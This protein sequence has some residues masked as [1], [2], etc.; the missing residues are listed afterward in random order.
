VCGANKWMQTYHDRMPVIL[1]EKDFDG[2][3]D[4]SLGAGA[5]KCAS[6][7]VLREWLVSK[8][9]NKAGEGDDDPTVLEPLTPELAI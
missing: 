4:G 1:D 9:I 6:E 8:R 7:S 3:L 2:W 5:L